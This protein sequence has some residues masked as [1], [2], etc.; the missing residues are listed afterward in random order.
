MEKTTSSDNIYISLL[1]FPLRSYSFITKE[2]YNDGDFN[3]VYYYKYIVII[4]S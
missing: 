3:C 2:S 1:R 4:Y